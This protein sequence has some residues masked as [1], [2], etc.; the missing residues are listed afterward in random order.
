[1]SPLSLSRH[2]RSL[3]SFL[4]QSI[5]IILCGHLIS[6]CG[7]DGLDAKSVLKSYRV[8]AIRSEPAALTL[9]TPVEME[10]F[11]FHPSD[12]TSAGRP[13]MSYTWTLCP[14]SLGSVGRYECLVDEVNID[15]FVTPASE[16]D[17]DE[18]ENLDEDTTPRR[19]PANLRLSFG[20]PDLLSLLSDSVME[21]M[22][23]LAM[24]SDMLGAEMSFF[25]AGQIEL[26]IKFEVKIEGE[27]TFSGVK[28]LPLLLDEEV[29][30]NLNPALNEIVN[31]DEIDLTK[32]KVESEVKWEATFAEGSAEEYTAPLSADAARQEQGESKSEETLL[33]SWYTTSGAFD[34]PVRLSEDTSTTLTVGEEPGRQRLYLTLRD[35]RGGVDL[36][37]LEFETTP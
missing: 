20:A 29:T 15:Q 18:D 25:D 21:Q 24:G 36:R 17:Q 19:P 32:L 1:M 26:Y 14:F 31:V 27:E 30:A 2:A 4:P 37:M 7:D 23:L 22:E 16:V 12:L 3:G 9:A 8:V 28:T 33:F 13:E 6:G 11:D 34:K 35:G 5:L 10:L